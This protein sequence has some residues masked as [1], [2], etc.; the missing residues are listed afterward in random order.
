V[1][2]V[3]QSGEPEKLRGGERKPLCSIWLCDL[4]EQEITKLHKG[5]NRPGSMRSGVHF[6]NM[7]SFRVK[8][9]AGRSCREQS[10][11]RAFNSLEDIRDWTSSRTR[12][13]NVATTSDRFTLRR[14]TT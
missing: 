1:L 10:G 8:C 2:G 14:G 13:K 11:N 9:G 3:L 7:A 12:V 5:F 4:V 6:L